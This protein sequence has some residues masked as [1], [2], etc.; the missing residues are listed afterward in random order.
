LD[1][2][3]TVIDNFTSYEMYILFL[4]PFVWMGTGFCV[5]LFYCKYKRARSEYDR[6]REE[7]ELTPMGSTARNDYEGD[8]QLQLEISN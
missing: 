4:I 3:C 1:E 2:E 6:L 8:N 7:R 5:L